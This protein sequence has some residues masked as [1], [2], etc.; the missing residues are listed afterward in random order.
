MESK[1]VGVSLYSINLQHSFVLRTDLLNEF[2]QKA[3]WL[4]HENKRALAGAA[5]SICSF[6]PSLQV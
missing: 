5:A 2:N 6:S 4:L 3:R 1:C